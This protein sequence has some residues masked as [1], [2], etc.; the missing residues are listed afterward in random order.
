MKN[1]L[2]DIYCERSNFEYWA[3]PINAITNLAFIISGLMI[4]YLIRKT[5][6][7]AVKDIVLWIFSGL[8]II[9]G[10][11][12]WLFH[13]HAN[14]W[15]MIVD[16]TPILLFVL[17]YTW[18]AIRRFASG[19][20]WVCSI[21]VIATLVLSF[22]LETQTGFNGGAY[23][24]PLLAMLIMGVFLHYFKGHPAGKALLLSCIIFGISL[25][26]RSLDEILCNNL[27]IGTHFL[28]HLL[29]SIV[30]YIVSRTLVL[31]SAQREK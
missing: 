18:F 1:N 29:N 26:F 7:A 31:N 24:S 22:I 17:L 12:S 10:I 30:L 14:K 6:K 9:I 23:L 2:I 16:I 21:A 8:I 27:P 19:S 20:I 13:T 25:T 28:W 11:G 15:A 5:S 3:E 4:V